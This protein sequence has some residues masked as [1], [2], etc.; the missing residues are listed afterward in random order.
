MQNNLRKLRAQHGVTVLELV[1]KARVSSA[2]LNQI[3]RWDYTPREEVR[4]RIAEALAVS[5]PEIW[6]ELQQ[7][8]V[9]A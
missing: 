7:Q 5:Q 3:E 8:A 9:G 1:T 2:T 6:P 4:Q